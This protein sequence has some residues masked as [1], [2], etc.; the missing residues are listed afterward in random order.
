ML[1]LLN[2]VVTRDSLILDDLAGIQ[3]PHSSMVEHSDAS[4]DLV[5]VHHS[6]GDLVGAM[7][8]F[9]KNEKAEQ[10]SSHASCSA[11]DFV[12]FKPRN[13]VQQREDRFE[14]FYEL[15]QLLGEGEFGEVYVGYQKQGTGFGEDRAV[16]I[17]DKSRMCSGDYEQ[18][19]N[20]CNL[21][22]GLTHP[23]LL[24]SFGRYLYCTRCHGSLNPEVSLL[25]RRHYMHSTKMKRAVTSLQIYAE[26]VN[27]GTKLTPEETSAKRLLPP[28]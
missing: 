14:D 21:L 25:C 24:V 19:I 20:E 8:T 17:I 22:K 12:Q 5:D 7:P 13:F 18:V 26:G 3:S 2:T 23:N 1:N 27:C 9:A 15:G 4:M 16:K 6:D 28:L 10:R 11:L